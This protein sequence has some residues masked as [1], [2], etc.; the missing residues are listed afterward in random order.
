MLVSGGSDRRL[1]TWS[2]N[3]Q[4]QVHQGQGATIRALAWSPDNHHLAIAVG[5]QVFFLN[6]QNG[7]TLA[8]SM[9][10]H[11][12]VVMALAWSPQQPQYLVSAGLDQLAV[13]WN[14]QS[15][16]PLTTFRQ[17]TSGILSAGWAADGQT[18]GTSSQGGVTRIWN[19][20]S[21]QQ[22]HGFY[23]ETDGAGNGVALN[24]LAFQPGGN[25]LAIGGMDGVVRLRQNGLTCQ[26]MG[27][28]ATQGQ[29][30][31]MPQRLTAHT[32]PLRALAWSP[33]GRFLATGGDDNMLNIWYPAQSQTPLLKIPQDAPV[34][35][36]NWS[37]NGKTIAAAAGKTV[38]LWAL[39]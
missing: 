36:L 25:M 17:H 10:V 34:L 3:G 24:A 33:D 32:K 37:P 2:P 23:L 12:G 35:A 27:Q 16:K 22:T 39:S 8:R 19:G 5:T 11:R 21:G 28:G 4:V 15:F 29:C 38:T 6:A 31:D 13:V 20:A 9:N 14:T 18:V 7:A 30:L 1:L 26:T